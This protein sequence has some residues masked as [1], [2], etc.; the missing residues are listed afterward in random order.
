[1][2]EET[3]TIDPE[4]NISKFLGHIHKHSSLWKSIELLM[5]N[6][7]ADNRWENLGIRIILRHASPEDIERRDQIGTDEFKIEHRVFGLDKL[8]EI[9]NAV[10]KGYLRIDARE[11]QLSG[12]SRFDILDQSKGG[13]KEFPQMQWPSKW[14]RCYG[15]PFS[16]VLTR[17][18][19]KIID[20]KLRMLETPY[21]DL[22]DLTEE[23][24]GY[25]VSAIFFNVLAPY[26]LAIRDCSIH[27]GNLSF[28]TL[29]HE[30]M[31]PRTITV[32]AI[33]SSAEA[34][35]ARR[36]WSYSKEDIT[37]EGNSIHSVV[38]SLP[39][40]ESTSA[41]LY[42]FQ[43]NRQMDQE[44]T[45]SREPIGRNPV[46]VGHYFFDPLHTRDAVREMLTKREAAQG[47]IRRIDVN[48]FEWCSSLLLHFCGFQADLLGPL[49]PEGIDVLAFLP[50]EPVALLVECVTSDVGDKF[51]KL[52]RRQKETQEVMPEMELVPV[53]FTPLSRSLVDE[54][55]I[56]EA[57][58]RSI[59]VI[60]SE[61]LQSLLDIAEA[62][63]GPQVAL[64]LIRKRAL[65]SRE[66]EVRGS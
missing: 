47:N 65:A 32:T 46:V 62:R 25:S 39:V 26:P 49:K 4:H 16:E 6:S 53:I 15:T 20:K 31:N 64:T 12:I 17:D 10:P 30:S 56:K 34:V 58:T 24:L 14:L 18:R 7:L 57:K 43:D 21:S 44:F 33:G 51:V 2:T 54:A 42:L 13:V 50:N 60:C 36:K 27:D 19:Q 37:D 48:A 29:Y 35:I 66:I 61:D 22:H 8:A 1:M 40:D 11:L 55:D 3:N 9:L 23:A 5:I 41:M 28:K 45:R 52:A 63:K 38:A 59:A